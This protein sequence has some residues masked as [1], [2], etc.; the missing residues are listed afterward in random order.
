MKRTFVT[1]FLCAMLMI[2]LS[3]KVKSQTAGTLTFTFTQTAPSS[4]A[5]QN[6]MAVWIEDSATSVFIK[7][8]MRYWSGGSW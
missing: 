4:Q 5:T 8:K 1:L 2:G 6:V 7:T 3:T